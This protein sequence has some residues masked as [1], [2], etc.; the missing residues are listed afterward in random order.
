[1]PGADLRRAPAPVPNEA[2]NETCDSQR[3]ESHLIGTDISG[4]MQRAVTGLNLA[5][6]EF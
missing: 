1:M 2:P 5:D 6:R 4:D 3:K